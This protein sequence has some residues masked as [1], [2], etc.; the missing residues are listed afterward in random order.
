MAIA[1]GEQSIEIRDIESLEQIRAVERLQIEVWG[2][3]ERDVVPLSQLAAARYV[4]GSLIGAFDGENMVGFVYGFLGLLQG[5]IVHHSHML[6][7]LPAYRS[8][9][10]AFRLKLAQ[11]KQVLADRVTDRITWT[12][13]PLQSLN[14]HFNF[15]KLGVVADT[16]KVNVYGDAGGSFLHR[17]GTDRF[18]VTW[19]INSRRVADHLTVHAERYP[20]A[21]SLRALLSS[22]DTGA[23]VLHK[24]RSELLAG[25]SISIEIPADIN[26]IEADD[27]ESAKQWRMETRGA[28][29]EA[30]SNGFIVTEYFL[31]NPQT[32]SYVLEKKLL[33]DFA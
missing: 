22:S 23:P 33:A 12:F 29:T 3:D 32:G 9:N 4:G 6:G 24:E 27:F 21:V 20:E 15:G 31:K 13:D 2:D 10:L 26:S 11:R 19:L 7:V 1:T 8:H 18:F 16:Y 17:N 28:F 5:R 25:D 30:L 14:A